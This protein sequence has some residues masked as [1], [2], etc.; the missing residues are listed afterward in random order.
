MNNK[1][2]SIKNIYRNFLFL[3]K[4]INFCIL[5]DNYTKINM[6]NKKTRRKKL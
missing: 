6:T 4:K 1:K 2:V 3:Y 5:K